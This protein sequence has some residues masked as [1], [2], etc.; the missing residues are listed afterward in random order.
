MRLPLNVINKTLRSF[1]IFQGLSAVQMTEL[2]LLTKELVVPPNAKLVS[3]NEELESIYI[4]IKGELLVVK[5]AENACRQ[6]FMVANNRLVRLT[7]ASR[8]VE[9]YSEMVLAKLYTYDIIGS[10]N[11]KS[12]RYGMKTGSFSAVVWKLPIRYL[13]SLEPRAT[14]LLRFYLSQKNKSFKNFEQNQVR[15]RLL[16]S[17]KAIKHNRSK[18]ENL[19]TNNTL[20]K[21]SSTPNGLVQRK[22]AIKGP[23]TPGNI[24]QSLINE[25]SMMRQNIIEKVRNRE[26][27]KPPKITEIKDS[28]ERANKIVNRYDFLKRMYNKTQKLLKTGASPKTGNSKVNVTCN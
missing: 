21:Y 11:A 9:R 24:H 2:S 28:I 22:F 3:E 6:K 15:L 26:V 20:S 19:L 5:T 8:K 1:E 7:D 25:N 4:L 10:W 17:N 12:S 13:K 14:K 27:N 18:S 16:R 23:Q